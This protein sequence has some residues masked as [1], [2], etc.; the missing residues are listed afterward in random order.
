MMKNK[1][2]VLLTKE[3]QLSDLSFPASFHSAKGIRFEDIEGNS[4][5]DMSSGY[6][7]VNVGWQHPKMVKSLQDQ[8]LKSTYAPPWMVSEESALLGEKLAGKMP[9]KGYKCF[10]A[11]GGSDANEI[12]RK[13]MFS[14]FG[15]CDVVSFYRSYHGGTHA[16]L[17]M[18]DIDAFRLPEIK[19]DYKEFKVEPPYCFRCPVKKDPS[20]CS[21]ECIGEIEKTLQ[22]NKKIKL[23]FAEPILGSGGVITP[24][25]GYFKALHKVC[26]S[27]GVALVMDEV[28]TGNGRTGNYLASEHFEI[29]PDAITLAK[30]L[31]SGFAAIGVAMVKEEFVESFTQFDDV[32]STFAWTP[33]SCAM[34]LKN[35]EIMEHEN[36]FQNAQI[37]GDYL[38]TN[39]EEIL[40]KYYPDQFGEVRGIGLMLGCEMVNNQ[41][42][43]ISNNKLNMRILLGM[44]KR[45]AMWC[46]SWD[47]STMIALPPLSITR[48]ECD[49]VLNILELSVKK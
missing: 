10:R 32:S 42:D 23:F 16:S 17:G 48:E 41:T 30:G 44:L 1:D 19:S 31:A 43:K 38:K 4:Y 29:A 25:K 33:L 47:Y 11:T 9:E 39:F 46:A 5:I 13:V 24:P 40:K 2:I 36:L 20:T 21:F 49:E 28:L 15:S 7:V 45:G 34:A 12:V 6:G 27:V 26:R 3:H 35:L 37:Q 22:A 14:K 18:S 8:A